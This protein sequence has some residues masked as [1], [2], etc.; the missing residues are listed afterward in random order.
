MSSDGP[1]MDDPMLDEP[2]RG[3]A[4]A[5]RVSVIV[6]LALAVVGAV[7]PGAPGRFSAGACVVVIVAVPLIRVVVQA[8][9][10]ARIR[11]LRFAF[12]AAGLLA[13]V[14]AGAIIASL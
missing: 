11:D 9:H 3:E 4:I 10:W 12:V 1:V 5:L 13:V 7:A 14:A 6:A 8:V 2:M